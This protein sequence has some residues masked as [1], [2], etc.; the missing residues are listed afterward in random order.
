MRLIS[1]GSSSAG[2]CYL[3]S[4]TGINVLI[5]IGVNIFLNTRNEHYFKIL[6]AD[7]LLISHEHIDHIKYLPNFL[8]VNQKAPVIINP[9]SLQEFK[10]KHENVYHINQ[11]RF[12]EL[13]YKQTYH[14]DFV[15]FRAF[16]VLHNSKANNGYYLNFKQLNKKGIYI[17]DA[18]SLKLS[19]LDNAFNRDLDFVM[20][21]SN[22]IKTPTQNDLKT[23][24]QNSELGH[25]NI[26]QTLKALKHI[27][28]VNFKQPKVIL[29][30]TSQN[31]RERIEAI[32]NT[33]YGDFNYFRT[34]KDY[35]EIDLC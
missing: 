21:E 4:D 1:F 5:D 8:K 20:I 29:I 15:E 6:N 7:Y 35:C 10:K 28:G 14:N 33:I 31:D 16:E 32:D 13:N 34:S 9:L 30:H 2:N 19:S 26:I 24:I 22:H 17:T 27:L 23:Q 3:L 25:F 11:H 12:V 18:G